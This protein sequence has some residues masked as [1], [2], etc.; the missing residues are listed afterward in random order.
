MLKAKEES[1]NN[2]GKTLELTIKND[3]ISLSPEEIEQLKIKNEELINKIS[4]KIDFSNLK[5]TLKKY[6]EE[7]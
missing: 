7:Y 1:E 5:D 6:K 3:E 2:D 4:K